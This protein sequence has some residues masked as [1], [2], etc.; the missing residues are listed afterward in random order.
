MHIYICLSMLSSARGKPSRHDGGALHS[1]FIS[2]LF[3]PPINNPELSEHCDTANYYWDGTGWPSVITQG[4]NLNWILAK[5][6]F[7]PSCC[8]ILPISIVKQKG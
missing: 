6:P 4:G 8:S 1:C 2:T 3:L 5:F 7:L